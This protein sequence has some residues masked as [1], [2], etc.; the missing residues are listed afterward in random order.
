MKKV[1]KKYKFAVLATDIIIFT[2]ESNK[3]KVLLIKMKKEPFNNCRAAP[4]GLIKPSEDIKSAAKRILQDKTN[5]RNVCLEQLYTFGKV[6]RD[7][8]GRVVSVAHMALIPSANAGIKTTKEYEEIGWFSV[9]DLPRLA[10]DHKEIIELA[11]ERL[12]AKLE[13]TNIVYGLLPIEFSLSQLQNTY[14]IILGRKLDKRN[15]RKKILSLQLV[16]MTNKTTI[17][18]THRPAI[19]YKFIKRSPQNIQ[20]L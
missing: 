12:R 8:F 18:E 9:D 3:L 5:I 1:T 20:I 6:K 19:L 2:I 13:Y 17:G 10:Y 11:L 4:G 16:K 14:E 7:P 15:F